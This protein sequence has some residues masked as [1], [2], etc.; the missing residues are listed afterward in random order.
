MAHSWTNATV[1]K[2]SVESSWQHLKPLRIS[3]MKLFQAMKGKRLHCKVI[4]L[5]SH[6]VGITTIIQD[7]DE[8]ALVSG[9]RFPLAA[10][11]C[12]SV[13]YKA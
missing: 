3:E 9:L 11:E 4:G 5:P 7:S 1:K 10:C 12:Q 2:S 6:I 8:S 13:P